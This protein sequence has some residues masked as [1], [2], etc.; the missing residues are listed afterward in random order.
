[1]FTL[2]SRCPRYFST[3]AKLPESPYAVD[4]RVQCLAAVAG[5]LPMATAVHL[6][7]C[8]V[9]LVAGG[10][11]SRLHRSEVRQWGLSACTYRS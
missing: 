11:L 3:V 9:A 4:T 2:V 10:L 6:C 8:V 5:Q 1:M 7:Q